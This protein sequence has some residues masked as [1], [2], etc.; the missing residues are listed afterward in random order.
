MIKCKKENQFSKFNVLKKRV[1]VKIIENIKNQIN[2]SYEKKNNNF[3]FSLSKLT[4]FV[5]VIIN[6]ETKDYGGDFNQAF[7]IGRLTILCDNPTK[8]RTAVAIMKKV[9][10]FNLIVSETKTT[11]KQH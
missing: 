7:G 6:F 9:E 4:N 10:Q 1:F 2:K 8:L 11:C 3:S 5:K